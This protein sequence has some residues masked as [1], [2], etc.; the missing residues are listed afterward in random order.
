MYRKT[1]PDPTGQGVF[2]GGSSVV[3][4]SQTI[5]AIWATGGF[6]IWMPNSQRSKRGTLHRLFGKNRCK[7]SVS[8]AAVDW[9]MRPQPRQRW[10]PLPPWRLLLRRPSLCRCRVAPPPVGSSAGSFATTPGQ[11]ART[12]RPPWQTQANRRAPNQG[13]PGA[14]AALSAPD[15][16]RLSAVV[17]GC[18]VGGGVSSA[19]PARSHR[20]PKTAMLICPPT[21]TCTQPICSTTLVAPARSLYGVAAGIVGGAAAWPRG[22]AGQQVACR[23]ARKPPRSLDG[24]SVADLPSVRLAA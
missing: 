18:T 13:R 15:L 4:S 16:P 20:R 14:S 8:R 3:K 10:F 21:E 2:R 12:E 5:A 24:T 17:C 22:N 19:W 23:L 11:P 7:E 9:S 6:T 1:L